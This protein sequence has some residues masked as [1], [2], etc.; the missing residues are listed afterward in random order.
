[1]LY[2]STIAHECYLDVQS[3]LSHLLHL[4]FIPLATEITIKAKI[5]LYIEDREE[6]KVF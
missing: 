5:T 4:L 3:F 6:E 2:L 1:M